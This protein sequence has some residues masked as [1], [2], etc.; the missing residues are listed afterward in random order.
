MSKFVGIARIAL[1]EN[2]Q[3]LE[4]PGR[5]KAFLINGIDHLLGCLISFTHAN[6]GSYARFCFYGKYAKVLSTS[7]DFEYFEKYFKQCL[8]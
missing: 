1:K 2:P 7:T 3:Y 8:V 4:M 6:P 5:C